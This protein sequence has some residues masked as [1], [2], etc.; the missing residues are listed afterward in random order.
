ML[1]DLIGV[2]SR[3]IAEEVSAKG[4]KTDLHRIAHPVFQFALGRLQ[5]R[6]AIHKNIEAHDQSSLL[7]KKVRLLGLSCS[8]RLAWNDVNKWQESSTH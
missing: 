4:L 2:R 6:M 7:G 3:T 1:S 8:E 5:Y